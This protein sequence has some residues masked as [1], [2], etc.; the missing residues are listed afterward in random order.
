MPAMATRPHPRL[1]RRLAANLLGFATFGLALP[2][3]AAMAEWRID[4][5][6]SRVIF[7]VEHAGFS[8]AIG[9]VSAPTGH[10]R[11]DPEGWE[12]ASVE[13][14][15]PMATLDFG[16]G[17]WNRTMQGRRWFDVARHPT[18]R[19]RSTRIEARDATQAVL[20]GELTIRDVVVPIVLHLRRNAVKR[21]PLTLRRTAGFSATA[22]LDR[23]AFGLEAYP[24]MIG[25]AVRVRIEVEA[26]RTRRA[27]PAPEGA[28]PSMPLE[29]VHAHPQHD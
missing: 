29:P 3:P 14:V 5:T 9:A 16:D 20:H 26:I 12:G 15:L 19:F 6:H 25:H 2:L 17:D 21:H 24:S 18:A 1:M 28:T 10:V 23:R 11:Y 27:P 4:P 8:Y 22:E 7:D 13:V